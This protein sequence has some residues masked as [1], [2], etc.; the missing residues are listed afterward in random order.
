M[1]LADNRMCN[2][3]YISSL[4]F[5]EERFFIVLESVI[6]LTVIGYINN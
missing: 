4:F 5:F 1:G 3:M 6:N 2:S